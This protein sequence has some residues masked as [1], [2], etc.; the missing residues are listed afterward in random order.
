M[1]EWQATEQ[2]QNLQKKE[3]AKKFD[4]PPK[5]GMLDEEGFDDEQNKVI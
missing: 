3:A 5:H 1:S 2:E 4:K